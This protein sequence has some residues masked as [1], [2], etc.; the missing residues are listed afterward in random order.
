VFYVKSTSEKK[1]FD[2]SEESSFTSSLVE[3]ALGALILAIGGVAVYYTFT[4]AD[5]LDG[6]VGFFGVLCI[7]LVVLGIVVLTA[8]TE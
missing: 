7:I 1:E 2:M 6:Y 3:R 4:S 5:A 8:K